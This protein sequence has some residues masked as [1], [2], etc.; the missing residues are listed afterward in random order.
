[1]PFGIWITSV[2]GTFWH[3]FTHLIH[4]ENKF[5]STNI[6]YQNNSTE[7]IIAPVHLYICS[8][9]RLLIE[10]TKYKEDNNI[11]QKNHKCR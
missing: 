9:S 10:F 6:K 8:I 3:I 11:Q 5:D 2:S 7:Y 1:M 4:N